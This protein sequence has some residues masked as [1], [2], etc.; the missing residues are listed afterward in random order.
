MEAFGLVPNI[1]A[2]IETVYKVIKFLEEI[3]S[4]GL[5]CN[6]YISEASSSY[7]ILEQVQQRLHSN[8]AGGHTV[9]PWSNHLQALAGE[10][11]VLK[12]YKS[13]MEQVMKILLQIKNYRFRRVF[14]WHRE[15][16]KIEDIFSKAERHKSAIQLA[17]SHDQL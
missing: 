5:D 15:K 3:K 13:D 11:G 16:G 9:Q 14:V 6:K 1:I 7:I 2:T 17:L 4:S 12:Q 8:A 10:D